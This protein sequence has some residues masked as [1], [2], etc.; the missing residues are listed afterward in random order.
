M[1]NKNMVSSLTNLIEHHREILTIV[2]ILKQK[3]N[4][5]ISFWVA[6]FVM[7]LLIITYDFSN[8]IIFSD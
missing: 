6:S 3:L 1:L 2:K 8:F 5:L 7:L 4:S